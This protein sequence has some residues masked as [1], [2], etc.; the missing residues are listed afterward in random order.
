MLLQG[1]STTKLIR[2]LFPCMFNIYKFKHAGI[3]INYHSNGRDS[4]VIQLVSL[5]PTIM[6]LSSIL[7]KVQTPLPRIY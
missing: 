1:V 6:I 2:K 3:C 4:V 5:I 7:L